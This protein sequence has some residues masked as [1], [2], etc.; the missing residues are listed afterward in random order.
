MTQVSKSSL[1]IN[2]TKFS[3][4][5]LHVIAKLI[6]IQLFADAKTREEYM[7]SANSDHKIKNAAMTILKRRLEKKYRSMGGF[8]TRMTLQLNTK[9]VS[10]A[11]K[12]A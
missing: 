11:A 2:T 4:K 12:T 8:R 5:D 9:Q 6:E 1:I 3:T 10:S 7:E